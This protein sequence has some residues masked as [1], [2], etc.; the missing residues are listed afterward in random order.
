MIARS[1]HHWL[2]AGLLVLQS[3][4]LVAAEFFTPPK[5]S[6]QLQD[7]SDAVPNETRALVIVDARLPALIAPALHEYVSAAA[8]RRQ[9]RITVLPIAELDDCPPPKLR[10]ALQKC[11]AARQGI[12]GVL[13]VG[14]VKLPSFFKGGR[15]FSRLAFRMTR[16]T[17]IRRGRS[18]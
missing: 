5:G 15:R 9:F 8:G 10:E 6:V 3:A 16:G 11:R 14:N 1:F 17:T 13:F 4:R 7:L 12:E 18:S 2:I